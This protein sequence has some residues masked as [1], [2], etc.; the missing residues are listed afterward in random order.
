MAGFRVDRTLSVNLFHPLARAWSGEKV[1]RVPILMYHGIGNRATFDHPYFDTNTTPQ[2]FSQH[3]RFLY[4]NG[5][6][7]LSLAD[8]LHHLKEGRT[9]TK[10]VVITFDDGQQ[11]F[12]T[13]AV[14][15]LAECGFTATMFLVTDFA[16]GGGSKIEG[17]PALNWR[18]VRELHSM[19]H[20]FGSHTVTHPQLKTVDRKKFDYEIADSKKTI[21]DKLGAAVSSFSY[22]YAFPEADSQLVRRLAETLEKNGYENGVST[23]I[24]TAGRRSPRFFLPRLPVNSWDDLRLFRAKLEGGYNWMHPVQYIRKAVGARFF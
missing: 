10:P 12:Y 19:G 4:E 8:S 14:P 16:D 21:E 13:E 11:D 7:T 20:R 15:A 22:P 1:S 24:G 18:E 3:M 9:D 6:H 2:V 5:Y 23:I 17:R